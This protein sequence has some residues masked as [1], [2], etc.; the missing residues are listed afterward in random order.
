MKLRNFII[1]L[2]ALLVAFAFASCKHEPK[3][4]PK[5]TPQPTGE[6]YQ[7][8]VT[9]GVD[10][11]YWN[12]DKIKLAWSGLK[13]NKGDTITLKYRSERDIYQWDI[14]D[15]SVR[16]WVYENQKNGLTDPVLG[17]DGWY[18]FTYTFGDG[19]VVDGKG[20]V[21]I[22]YPYTAFGIYFRGNFK[23][24]TRHHDVTHPVERLRNLIGLN[25]VNTLGAVGITTL[26]DY[27]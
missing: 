13:I 15:N 3:V 9:Q 2:F 6:I 4:D 14:R 23:P 18:T 7:I 5:P 24:F 21:D 22:G 16:Y 17:D 1:V 25:H 19:I 12:R 20:A 27:T 26:T 11:D 10:K 8:Q